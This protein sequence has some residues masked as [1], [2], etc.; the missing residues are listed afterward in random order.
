MHNSRIHH[1]LDALHGIT[2]LIEDTFNDLKWTLDHNISV[3]Y[4]LI[5]EYDLPDE[6]VRELQHAISETERAL[7]SDIEFVP[8]S[9]QVD[10]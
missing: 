8:R 2:F 5:R 6:A 1:N 10:R 4:S 3:M 7:Q 9:A